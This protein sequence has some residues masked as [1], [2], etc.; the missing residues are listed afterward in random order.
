MKLVSDKFFAEAQINYIMSNF[1]FNKVYD[2]MQHL[3]W[4][5]IDN[6]RCPSMKDL[7]EAAHERL[8]TAYESGFCSSGGFEAEYDSR[9]GFTTGSLSCRVKENS[10]TPFRGMWG[11]GTN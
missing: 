4:K 3:D 7:K 2:V 6:P 8:W 1:D 5:W 11:A 9:N 10:W